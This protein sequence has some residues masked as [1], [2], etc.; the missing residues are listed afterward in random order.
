M[1]TALPRSGERLPRVQEGS[2][3]GW[4][5]SKKT[6]VEEK[7]PED[8]PP[9]GSESRRTIGKYEIG[10]KIATGGFGTVYKAWDPMIRRSVAVKTCE[11]PDA[12]V[13]ARVSR[14]AQLAG[15]LQHPN[16]TTVY[17]FGVEGIV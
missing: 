9:A 1:K 10:E 14:E 3:M 12:N 16:I 11:V 15:S 2:L 8:Q 17:Q 7:P 13:R 6:A 4:F 5:G